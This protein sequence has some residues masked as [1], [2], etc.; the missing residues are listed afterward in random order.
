MF[1]PTIA[2]ASVAFTKTELV[3][4]LPPVRTWR[5]TSLL[6]RVYRSPVAGS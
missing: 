3:T 6:E 4:A 1:W 5:N 2:V